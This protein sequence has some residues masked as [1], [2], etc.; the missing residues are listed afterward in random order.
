MKTYYW[1]RKLYNGYEPDNTIKLRA[2]KEDE[3][4]YIVF[5]VYG[6]VTF[7]DGSSIVS[8]SKVGDC[9]EWRN[10]NRTGIENDFWTA[11]E[12]LPAFITNP[13]E[14]EESEIIEE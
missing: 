7:R 8:I 12:H 2:Y 4:T 6:F 14:Y 5:E 9:F 13:D 1:Y 10:D 11:W 3:K